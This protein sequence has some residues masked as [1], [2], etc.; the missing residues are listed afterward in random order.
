MKAFPAFIK[1]SRAASRLLPLDVVGSDKMGANLI[2]E[3]WVL[4]GG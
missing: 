1:R 2:M 3:E 4:T